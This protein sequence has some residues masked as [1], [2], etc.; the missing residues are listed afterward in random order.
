MVMHPAVPNVLSIGRLVGSVALLFTGGLDAPFLILFTL[1]CLTDLLD[2]L[3]ARRYGIC[4]P[5]GEVLD[6]IAD[7][8]LVVCMLTVLISSL[9]WE[10]W[11]IALIGCV[12]A[13][14]GCVIALRSLS[15]AIGTC[16]FGEPALIHT[17][18]NKVSGLVIRLSPFML[19]MFDTGPVVIVTCAVSA[20]ASFEELLIN[21]H[22]D[23]LDRNRRS[24]L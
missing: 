21:I 17:Y 20:L 15:V 10:W 9:E 24:Y 13:L 14:I 8:A 11:M 4:T 2:G 18:S 5:H 23:E 16:R 1:L 3:I 22:S 7:F 6:S 12:I 19:L